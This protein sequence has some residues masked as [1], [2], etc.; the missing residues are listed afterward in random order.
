[1]NNN[2]HLAASILVQTFPHGQFVAVEPDGTIDGSA[3]T[4]I[5]SIDPEFKD[6][7]WK[8]ITANSMFTN[9][10]PEGDILPNIISC[11]YK[12]V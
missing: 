5:V 12:G 9:H 3:S 8:E 4:L 6:H 11:N 7:T 10:D 2:W 1:M